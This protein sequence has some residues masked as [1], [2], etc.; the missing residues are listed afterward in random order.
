V[1][2]ITRTAHP[3]SEKS[4]ARESAVSGMVSAS[5]LT[6]IGTWVFA[7]GMRMNGAPWLFASGA[8]P[9]I[10]GVVMFTRSLWRFARA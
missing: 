3:S 5:V 6:A 8:V 10:V 2:G 4:A 1:N 7:W 9:W